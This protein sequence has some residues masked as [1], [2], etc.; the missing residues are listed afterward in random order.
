MAVLILGVVIFLGV[1]SIRLVADSWRSRQIVRLGERGWKGLYSVASLV[2]FVLIV[3]GYG[4]ARREPVLLWVP[5]AGVRHLTALLVA[6][7]FVLIAA[8]Y[9]PGNH[10]KRAVGHPMMAGVVLWAV[11]HLIANGT[12]NA[13]LLFGAFF[14]W[15]AAGLFIWR[16]RDRL[17][18]TQYPVGDVAGDAR[19]VIV[20]LVA[21]AL[22]AFLL[23]GWLIGVRPLG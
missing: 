12:F 19:T 7:A 4:L 11:G 21:W 14:V 2:G 13:V 16:R 18:G 6:I 20:G 8:A 5:P 17:A 15:A 10:I 22:F 9:V 3:W 23:H 1:H